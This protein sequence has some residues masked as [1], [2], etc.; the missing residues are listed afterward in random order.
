MAQGSACMDGGC[1]MEHLHNLVAITALGNK[2]VGECIDAV[3]AFQGSS[4]TQA[5]ERLLASGQFA[6][7]K[8]AAIVLEEVLPQFGGVLA[9]IA[10]AETSQVGVVIIMAHSYSFL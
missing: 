3:G 6:F 8:S 9:Q 5:D 2:G 1:D 7:R 10:L 4:A